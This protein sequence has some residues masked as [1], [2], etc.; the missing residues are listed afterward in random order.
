MLV[1]LFTLSA[2]LLVSLIILVM[3]FK[4]LSSLRKK[5]DGFLEELTELNEQINKLK[6][7]LSTSEDRI[8]DYEKNQPE[9]EKALQEQ[10]KLIGENLFNDILRKNAGEYSSTATEKIEAI[11]K[12]FKEDLVKFEKKIGDESEKRYHLGEEVKKL[13]DLNS[14]LSKN[15]EN[16]TEALLGNVKTMGDWGEL[17]LERIL[18]ESGLEKGREYML[19]EQIKDESGHPVVSKYTDKK[20]I[21]DA[22]IFYPDNRF[23][24]I[25][26]KVS[27]KQFSESYR[28]NISKSEQNE[29]LAAHVKSITN[30]FK[31]LSKKAYDQVSG[32]PDFVIMFIPNDNAFN[33]ALKTRPTLW[34]E[35]YKLGV[36][37][38]NPFYLMT[39]VKL[40]QEMYK[41]QKLTDQAEKIRERG[42]RMIDKVAT[43][44]DHLNKLGNSLKTTTNHYNNSIS[45]LCGKNSLLNQAQE[46]EKLGI[47]S[48]KSNKNLLKPK[49]IESDAISQSLKRIEQSKTKVQ[50]K[51]P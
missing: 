21:P 13:M 11:L 48:S 38:M 45:T 6:S 25:D 20:M 35:A 14:K 33:I 47:E 29:L 37:L 10:M 9:R 50:S 30:H 42:E 34:E 28:T 8:K 18:E 24:I 19:Q 27:I 44:L 23:L 43:L 17:I 31:E 46:M 15:A 39:A 40:I 49:M 12:P 5:A 3:V 51:I 26:S 22:I 2:V 36:L 32:T 7:E 41:N 4:N 16:L 1:V